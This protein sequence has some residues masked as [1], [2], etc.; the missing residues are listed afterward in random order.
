M[1]EKKVEKKDLVREALVSYIKLLRQIEKTIEK[2]N[3]IDEASK[4]KVCLLIFGREIADTK[5]YFAK[6]VG[7]IKL[8]LKQ[9]E[10]EE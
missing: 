5:G 9:L 3:A 4:K 1:A 2:A 6:R 7:F 8:A 10:I